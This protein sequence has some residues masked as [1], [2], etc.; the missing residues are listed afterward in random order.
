MLFVGE[1]TQ[2]LVMEVTALRCKVADL[3]QQLSKK[4]R[5]SQ[6]A[7]YPCFS[8]QE[9][10]GTRLYSIVWNLKALL[11]LFFNYL[12][13]QKL[14]ILQIFVYSQPSRSGL[15][16]NC[17]HWCTVSVHPNS[18]W[19]NGENNG[20]ISVFMAQYTLTSISS[21]S[22]SV[23]FPVLHT[24]SLVVGQDQQEIIARSVQLTYA[25]MQD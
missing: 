19:I 5:E 13:H 1:Q 8:T 21:L 6:L 22:Q 24:A 23:R 16:Q 12:R 15:A 3:H 20:T 10:L 25:P 14:Y 2:G 18:G 11:G 7:S 17:F 9:G 4:V